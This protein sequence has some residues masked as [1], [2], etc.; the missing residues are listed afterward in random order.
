MSYFRS[1]SAEL[2]AGILDHEVSG[3][4]LPFAPEQVVCSLRLPSAEAPFVTATVQG[5]PTED[6]FS[7][8][9]SA[10]IPEDG[11]VLD[12]YAVGAEQIVPGTAS[13][14]VGYEEL[15]GV[16]ARFLG[17][18]PA[19]LTEAQASEVDSCIQ[20]G[21]R[22]FYYPPR[23]EGVDETYEWSFLRQ[24]CSV[25]TSANVGD[26]R[27]ADGFGKVRGD[28]YFGGDDI[29]M[30]PLAVVSIG[31]LLAFRRRDVKGPPKFAAFRFKQAY[32]TSGQF[33]ELM[34][35][36]VPDRAYLLEFGGEAD[37]GRISATKP[38]P[39]G[40]PSFSELVTESC[41]AIAE[42]RSNDEAGLHTENFRNLLVSM[43]AKDRSRSGAWFGRV[44]DRPDFVPPPA[45]G[46]RFRGGMRITY[47]GQEL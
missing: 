25:Q 47:H 46:C 3:L 44:G 5:A 9:F 31:Q 18:D 1:G 13:L 35:Y 40:G 8:A 10:P 41:L 26:Y 7:V 29:E 2:E 4:S 15:T 19:S 42:Q 21:I 43:I 28:I 16:V 39:L 11:Y 24:T 17:Y 20:A 27:M 6:G 14:A 34:L 36:P 12:W 32:G 23:M 37:T 45:P 33:V 22:N 38:F 30:R